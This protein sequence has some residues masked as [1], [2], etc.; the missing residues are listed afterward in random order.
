MKQVL[1]CHG[2]SKEDKKSQ[3]AVNTFCEQGAIYAV[4][5]YF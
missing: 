1:F 4:T 2:I 3:Q 5:L